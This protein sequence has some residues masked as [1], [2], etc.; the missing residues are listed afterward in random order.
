[1]ADGGAMVTEDAASPCPG[2]PVGRTRIQNVALIA[3]PLVFSIMQV[4]GPP[5]G[6]SSEGWVVVG[7]LFLMALWWVTEAIPIPITS[8]LPLIVLPLFGVRSIQEASA[9]YADKIIFLLLGGFIIARSVERWKLHVRLALLTVSRAG[10]KPSGLVLGFLCASAMLSAWISN[11]ATSIMLMPVALSVAFSLGAQ[12]RAGSTLAVSLCLA[13]AY[14]ASIGGLATPVGTPTNLIVIGALEAAGDER[15]T[16]A[17]WMSFGVP[18]VLCLIPLAWLVLTKLSGPIR[19]PGGDPQKVLRGRLKALGPWTRPEVRTMIVF[20]II[21]SFWIF[22]RA[23]I[24]DI[25]IFGVQPF[26][27]L[28]DHVIAIMGAVAMFLVPAGCRNDRG[29]MLLDWDTAKG[30]PWDVVLLFGGGLS[31]AAAITATGLGGW[32][33]E[34][35]QGVMALP[36]VLMI[37]TISLVINFATEVTSNVAT[38]AAIMPVILALAAAAGFD[39]AQLA[40]PVALSAS[41]A[42]MFPMATAPNAIAFASGEVSIP[43]MARVGVQLNLLSVVLVSL[44]AAALTPLLLP[45]AG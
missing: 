4:L 21:A 1:M 2:R 5:P 16:F 32:L 26:A 30:L 34:Q 41:C 11:T 28:T 22:R 43:R 7:L 10:A 20:G 45:S 29:A 3:G 35:M 19:V 12:K 40:I 6:L 25:S 17:R 38:A 14:G 31:L 39:P 9:P 18:A 23:F 36:I 15:L 27:G 42:F 24:Q 8:L 37:L 44:I 13:V 33:G